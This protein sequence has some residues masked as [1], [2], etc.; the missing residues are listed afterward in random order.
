MFVGQYE[1][2]TAAD[3]TYTFEGIDL[4]RERARLREIMW[5]THFRAGAS[6]IRAVL[7]E[8][9]SV[10]FVLLGS[11]RIAGAIQNMRGGLPSVLAVRADE[12]PLARRAHC[13]QDGSFALEDVPPGEYVLK[14]DVPEADQVVPVTVTVGADQTATATFVMAGSSVELYVR[15]P[16]GQG[17][18]LMIEPES[19]GAGIGGRIRGI[20][21]MNGEDRCSFSYVR[22]GR[23]R[24]LLDGTSCQSITVTASPDEQEID[25]RG[26]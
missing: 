26:R 23:Y 16:A 15:V 19:E 2:T 8:D 9:A 10:D 6:V 1:T 3:G 18:T 14:L 7:E 4:A 21:R 12:P 22:P 20:M 17:R 5:A 13:D 25:L 11:G 24:V